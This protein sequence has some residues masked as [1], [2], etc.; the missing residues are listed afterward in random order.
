MRFHGGGG[1]LDE[2]RVPPFGT[3]CPE[4]FEPDCV[5]QAPQLAR[6]SRTGAPAA[7]RARPDGGG[8]AGC[9]ARRLDAG[10]A[11]AESG[12]GAGGCGKS[13]R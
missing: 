9:R 13:P 2:H 3:G 4:M 11:A 10:E 6:R 7:H 12:A 8:R 1:G 5:A